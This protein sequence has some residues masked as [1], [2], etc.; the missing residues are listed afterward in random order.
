M[1]KLTPEKA[2]VAGKTAVIADLH[3]GIEN[4]MQNVGIA[5]PRMQ[6]VDVISKVNE[7]VDKYEI[8]KLIIAG[9]LKH[10]FAENLPYEWDDVRVFL[11]SID[12]EISVVRG[13]HDNYL[14]AILS[15]Y[16]IDLKDYERIEDLY[17]VHGHKDLGFEKVIMGHEHPAIKFRKEGVIYSYSCFLVADKTKFVLP[18]FSPL[19][20]GSDVLQG[21]FLSPILRNSKKIEVYAVEDEVL[22][23][24][25]LKLL[26][27]IL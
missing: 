24:G 19:V 25:E 9:D 11:D 14:S 20:S 16:S 23:L 8:E 12:V 7:I 26:R 27:E 5:I 10:E 4:A 13:N 6:I 1:L 18:A 17:V 15:E 2:I 21:E 3:L 22:Y